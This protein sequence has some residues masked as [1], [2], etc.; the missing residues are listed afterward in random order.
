MS[1]S[2]I[3]SGSI[4]V[5]LARQFA[6]NAIPVGIANSR[7]PQSMGAVAGELGDQVVPMTLQEALRA[8]VILLAVPF[9]AHRDVAGA[10]ASWAGKVVIDVT[11]AYGVPLSELDQLPSSA[12][13][14]KALPGAHLVKAFNH[15]PAAVLAQEPAGHGVRRVIFVSGDDDGATRQVAALVERLG[16]APVALGKIEE[17]GRLVQA[18]D[19]TWAPLI[20]QDL[21]K[22]QA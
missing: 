18:R 9:R 2:I 1:Y 16:F 6:R 10:L 3:G 20:F 19:K 15:L 21:F 13:V 11:N 17:G 5:A 22:K 14:A 8:D 12:V 4:G 7:G